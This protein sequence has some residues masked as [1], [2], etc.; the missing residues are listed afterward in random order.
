MEATSSKSARFKP[1]CCP[2]GEVCFT[3]GSTSMPTG[4]LLCVSSATLSSAVMKSRTTSLR[5]CSMSMNTMVL[6][7]TGE[8]ALAALMKACSSW[9]RHA[10]AWI[11]VARSTSRAPRLSTE[12]ACR[13]S[14]P[15]TSISSGNALQSVVSSVSDASRRSVGP[16]AHRSASRN[17]IPGVSSVASAFRGE[18]P[19]ASSAGMSTLSASMYG[20]GFER[21]SAPWRRSSSRNVLRCFGES[22]QKRS[23]SSATAAASAARSAKRSSGPLS[24]SAW[25]A[26]ENCAPARSSGCAS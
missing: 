18:G 20:L 21:A 11:C 16:S 2:P 26:S 13:Q 22:R 4:M 17:T 15:F 1:G 9:N 14:S 24:S 8:N 3:T 23:T 5:M 12:T 7:T 10:S 19:R 25:K 6:Y